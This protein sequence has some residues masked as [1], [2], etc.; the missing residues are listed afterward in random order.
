MERHITKFI[1]ILRHQNKKNV[2][3]SKFHVMPPFKRQS[4]P[5]EAK[6]YSADQNVS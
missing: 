2:S 3:G 1:F 4:L 5:G 6:G